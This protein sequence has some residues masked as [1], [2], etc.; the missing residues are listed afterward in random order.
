MAYFQLRGSRVFVFNW[1]EGRQV[2]LPRAQTRHLDGEPELVVKEWVA[3]W[4]N[5]NKIQKPTFE[6]SPLPKSWDKLI[7]RFGETL[8][9]RGRQSS[10]TAD[11]LRNLRLTL[12]FFIERGCKTFAD[13]PNY[14]RKL[15]PWLLSIGKT[16][17]RVWALNQSVRQFWLWLDDEGLASGPLKLTAGAKSTNPTP[18]KRTLT[19]EEI[20]AFECTRE[21]I[22]LFIL[23]GYFFSLRPQEVIALRPV[24]FKAGSATQTL[25]CSLV[26][27]KCGL[28]G[29]LAVNIH[30]QKNAQG[31]YTKPKT[32]SGG[33]VACFNEQAARR[34]ISALAGKPKDQ[35]L[36]PHGLYWYCTLWRRHS[37]PSTVSKDMR[38]ASVYWLGH[39]SEMPITALKNHARHR[40]IETTT[41]YTRRPEELNVDEWSELSL[42]D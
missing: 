40:L 28:Y 27:Q 14:S 22:G 35:P 37:I 12:P 32:G 41:L 4:S 21:D 29:R 8:S 19:P 25:E 17:R 23:L 33:W 34:I 39:Y 2:M 31:V 42:D 24:D 36:F 18:L 38:R 5:S 30:R 15:G 11:H 6:L 16:P 1:L 13:F 3:R 7:T 10:T 26:M 9:N 20:L